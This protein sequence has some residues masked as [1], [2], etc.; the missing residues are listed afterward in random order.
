[1]STPSARATHFNEMVE[2]LQQRERIREIFGR[3]VTRQ[4]ADEILSGRVPLGGQRTTATVLFA[5]IRGFT[6]LSE[7][8]AP[9]EVV[10]LSASISARWSPVCSTA[11]ASSPTASS[12]TRSWRCLGCR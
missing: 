1:M 3:Y 4:V 2:G 6:R 9:E 11:A 7:E 12:A 5:D 8:L 10:A